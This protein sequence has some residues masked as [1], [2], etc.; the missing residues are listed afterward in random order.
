MNDL[1]RKYRYKYTATLFAG[2]WRHDYQIIGRHGGM[3][4]HVDD[5][6]ESNKHFP[7][8]YSAGLEIHYRE[9]PAY[10]DDQ[11]P[12]HDMCWLLRCPCWHDGTTAYAEEAL[13]PLFDGVNHERLFAKLAL[14]SD[15]R[16]IAAVVK[17]L[18]G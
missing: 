3:N 8:R 2:K 15:E 12:S 10:M 6:G 13:L 7:Q 14:E 16:F 4:F 9:P 11:P 18:E 5:F 1:S 17:A